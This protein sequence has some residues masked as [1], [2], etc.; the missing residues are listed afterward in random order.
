LFYIQVA[1]VVAVV[2]L[3]VAHVVD[4]EELAVALLPLLLPAR[5]ALE[6]STRMTLAHSPRLVHK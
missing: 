6:P 3:A 4:A 1:H 5:P 2:V